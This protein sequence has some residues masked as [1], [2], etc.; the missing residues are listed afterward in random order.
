MKKN[1]SALI[2]LAIV[3]AA[4][5]VLACHSWAQGLDLEVENPAEAQAVGQTTA[6]VG[7]GPGV[8]PEY[9][10]SD[11]YKLVPIPFVSVKFSND[12]SILWVANLARANLIPSRT[13]MAGPMLQYIQERN[14]V[15]NDKVD[16]LDTVDASLMA[17]GFAGVRVDRFSFSLE[18][19]QDIADG[20]DGA[21][22]RLRGGYHLLAGKVWNASLNAFTT[23]A[24]GDYMSAYFGINRRNSDKSGLKT[25]NA[26]SGFKDV[27]VALP[28]TYSPWEHW[29]I[30]GAVAYK[31]LLGDAAD[32]PVVDDEGNANQFI[33]GMLLIYRF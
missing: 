16:K 15:D 11:D 13:W 17:G 24:D 21:I 32:S 30:M 6:A 14:H 29:S 19:M 1:Y 12:M 33:G 20:N 8:A 27:G 18:A 7:L 22:V 31:R 9:E 25:F 23:W 28:V 2:I 4:S 26:D 10:G 3:V 5:L